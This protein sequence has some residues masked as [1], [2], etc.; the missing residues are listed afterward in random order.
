MK[1][2]LLTAGKKCCRGCTWLPHLARN[3]EGYDLMQ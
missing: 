2:Y 1:Y 3:E